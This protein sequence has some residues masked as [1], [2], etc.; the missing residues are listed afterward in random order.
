MLE[1]S[2]HTPEI[3]WP[4]LGDILKVKLD[5]ETMDTVPEG[6]MEPLEPL[7]AVRV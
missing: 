3:R 5:P 2:T 1:P 7:E 6:D 4:V